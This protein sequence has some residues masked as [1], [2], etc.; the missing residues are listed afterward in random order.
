LDTIT[1]QW[2]KFAVELDLSTTAGVGATHLIHSM[3][4]IHDA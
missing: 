2:I 4:T 3:C 1:A